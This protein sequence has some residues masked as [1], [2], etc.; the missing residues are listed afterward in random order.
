[1]AKNTQGYLQNAI[2]ILKGVAIKVMETR[3]ARGCQRGGRTRKPREREQLTRA[4][5]KDGKRMGKG[6]DPNYIRRS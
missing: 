1:M 4:S 6:K 5:G 3:Y 2:Q